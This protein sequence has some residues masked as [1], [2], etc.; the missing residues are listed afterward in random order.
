[1]IYMILKD[2]TISSR[3]CIS[4]IWTPSVWPEHLHS[5]IFTGLLLTAA[6]GL[7]RGGSRWGWIDGERRSNVPWNTCLYFQCRERTG[8]IRERP[9]GP[10]QSWI[11]DEIGGMEPLHWLFPS[12]S[13][14]TL[15]HTHDIQTIF[16]TRTESRRGSNTFSLQLQPCTSQYSCTHFPRPSPCLHYWN[17]LST[18][19]S[20]HLT[21][22][23][24]DP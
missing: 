4:P 17:P 19:F 21:H 11:I 15:N 20:W 23:T 7:W 9:H 5:V 1:M 3:W 22:R 16:F 6:Q 12:T 10:L 2:I 18:A 8:G 13:V 24:S 14:H